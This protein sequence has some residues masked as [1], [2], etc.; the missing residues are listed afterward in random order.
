MVASSALFRTALVAAAAIL[1]AAAAPAQE[2][3]QAYPTRTITLVVAFPPGGPP[4]VVARIVGAAMSDIL[5]KPIVIENK[6]GASG[7]IAAAGVARAAPDGYTLL[8]VDIA[9]VV[10]PSILSSVGYDPIKDFKMV[11]L[12]ART[13]VTMVAS[14][15]LG[16]KNLKELIALAKSKPGELK[17]PHSGVGTP[18]HLGAVSFL[19]ETGTDMLLVPYRGI[20]IGIQDVVA[21][22]VSL[23]FSGPSTTIGLAR[24]GKVLMLGTTGRQRM[25]AMPD[26][27]TFEENG[28]A[29]KGF[30]NGQW[31]GIG[32]PAGTPDAIIA[33]LNEA[34]GKALQKKDVQERLAKVEFTPVGGTPQELGRLVEQ[35]LAYWRDTMRAAGV[36][37]Q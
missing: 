18:P 22:H 34:Q 4:D 30:D 36:K 2:T 11:G 31:F 21:G 35:Q 1:S 29:L 20:A 26:V 14:P 10:G 12:S 3:S 7:S 23:L 13:T 32:A 33:R 27:P 19:Q 6:P 17:V 28:V 8:S 25:A 24:E 15:A 5:G 9:L 16:V 37:P